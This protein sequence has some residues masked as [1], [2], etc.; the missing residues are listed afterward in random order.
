MLIFPAIKILFAWL[1]EFKITIVRT[2]EDG[3]AKYRNG[4]H[5]GGFGV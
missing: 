2:D 5:D 1:C 3:E 4:M